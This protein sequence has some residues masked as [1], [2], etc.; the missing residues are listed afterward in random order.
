MQQRCLGTDIDIAAS[1]FSSSTGAFDLIDNPLPL[2]EF[3][4]L[5]SQRLS[6]A[7]R[8]YDLT[9]HPVTSPDDTGCFHQSVRKHAETR[10]DKRKT[11]EDA[12]KEH[13]LEDRVDYV[14]HNRFSQHGS[15]I[16]RVTP[17]PHSIDDRGT[18]SSFVLGSRMQYQPCRSPQGHMEVPSR[19]CPARGDNHGNTVRRSQ[20]PKCCLPWRC[21]LG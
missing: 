16:P 2:C 20:R 17:A 19:S 4:W 7:E 10:L 12:V 11:V 5:F 13:Y 18:R 9:V 8:R 1:P 21:L 6:E 3:F 14:D 15:A